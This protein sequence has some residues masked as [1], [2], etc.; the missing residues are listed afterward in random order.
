M[1]DLGDLSATHVVAPRVR[2]RR[3]NRWAIALAVAL[4][5]AIAASAPI[6][7]PARL[8]VAASIPFGQ[9]AHLMIDGARAIVLDTRAA[10]DRI[11]S[12]ALPGGRLEWSTPVAGSAVNGDLEAIDGTVIVTLPSY[13]APDDLVEAIDPGTGRTLWQKKVDSILVLPGGLL[14]TEAVPARSATTISLV[15]PHRGDSLWS[16]TISTACQLSTANV[17]TETAADGLVELCPETGELSVISLSTG[18]VQARRHID[19]ISQGLPQ[20]LATVGIQGA[21]VLFV[22]PE[23]IV[24]LDRYPLMTISAFRTSDLKPLWSGLPMTADDRIETCGPDVCLGGD[25]TAI[26]I[27]PATGRTIPGTQARTGSSTTVADDSA[28]IVVPDAATLAEISSGVSIR[29]DGA[30]P[31]PAGR[32]AAVPERGS[33]DGSTWIA[34]ATSTA[35]RLVQPLHG[36]APNACIAIATYIACATGHGRLTIWGLP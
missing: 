4:V 20:T 15:S 17:P 13:N 35:I 31:T 32:S 7:G 14:V 30:T 19:L 34:L 6:A 36:V 8:A 5:T 9:N 24:A 22:G 2:R 23:T 18:H 1:I 10:K 12:Y 25:Q 21:G 3:R 26:V 29:P 33:D 28:L 27:D 16:A 11:S